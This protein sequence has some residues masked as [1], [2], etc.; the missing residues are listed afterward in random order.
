MKC[1][2]CNNETE[3]TFNISFERTPICENCSSKITYQYFNWLM[4][5]RDIIIKNEIDKIAVNCDEA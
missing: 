4:D 2:I 1:K 5:H 3:V